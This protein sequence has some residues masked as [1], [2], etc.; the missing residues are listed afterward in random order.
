L[1]KYRIERKGE[2]AK[3]VLIGGS[4]SPSKGRPV[5]VWPEDNINRRIYFFRL[6]QLGRWI[7]DLL[8]IV[9][10][11]ESGWLGHSYGGNLIQ[12]NSPDPNV[13][14]ADRSGDIAFFYEKVSD[15]QN[16]SPFKT[17][18]FAV[19]LSDPDTV[20]PGSEIKVAGVQ[21]PALPSTRRTGGGYLLE[22]PRPLQITVDGQTFFI[23]GF[24]S[25]DFP[26]DSYYVNA[27]WSRH[28]F[29]PYQPILNADGKD[30]MD[31]GRELKTRYGLSWVGRPSFY[32]SPDGHFEMLFHGV[33]K[34]ILPDNDYTKWPSAEKYQLW[35]FYRCLFKTSIDI[36]L[37]NNGAPR[38][39]ILA[40]TDEG[41][42]L[43]RARAPRKLKR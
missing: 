17:E 23:V 27:M 28:L 15:A 41:A 33:I 5:P 40:A 1:R 25:G 35:E 4:M 37:D 43:L 20:V 3:E 6:N 29:G 9:E 32:K 24:S 18:I 11:I 16:D 39:Q 38:I 30:L 14:R 42:A 34:S 13:I 7:R 22:G 26:T 21:S 2:L 10:K 19:R 8:P 36:T 31:L 12:E